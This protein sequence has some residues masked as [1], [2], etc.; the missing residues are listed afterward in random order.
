MADEAAHVWS[1]AQ[2]VPTTAG[3]PPAADLLAAAERPGAERGAVHP[4]Y[5]ESADAN[6][7]AVGQRNQRFE[8]GD[9]TGHRQGHSEGGA[10]SAGPGGVARCTDQGERRRDRAQPGGELARRLAV[11]APTGTGWLRILPEADRRMR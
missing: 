2:L 5:A 9:G 8:R 4:A 10:R 6:E 1:A 11:G 3:G 7:R